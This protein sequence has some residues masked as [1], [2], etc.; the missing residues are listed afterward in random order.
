MK[1][2]IVGSLEI[3]SIVLIVIVVL[4]GL[5]NGFLAAGVLGA[6]AGAIVGFAGAVVVFGALLTLLEINESLR[7][8]RQ[9]LE[10]RG[11]V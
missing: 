5:I 8:I 2:L 6:I 7:A 4:A 3:L 9:Q 10:A 1:R 11:R